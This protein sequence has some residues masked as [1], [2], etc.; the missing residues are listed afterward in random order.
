MIITRTMIIRTVTIFSLLVVMVIGFGRTQVSRAQSGAPQITSV[1]T[2]A[3]GSESATISYTANQDVTAQVVYDTSAHSQVSDYRST[4]GFNVNAATTNSFQL[5]GLQAG[6]TYHFRV[7]IKNAGGQTDTSADR[8]LTT[9]ASAGAGTGTSLIITNIRADCTA[10]QCRVAYSTNTNA[11]VELRWDLTSQ[12][13]FVDYQFSTRENANPPQSGLRSLLVPPAGSPGGLTAR[14]PYHYRLQATNPTVGS[15]VTNDLI[16]QTSSSNSDHTFS[17]GSCIVPSTGETV[18][19][20]SCASTRQYCD[21]GGQLV[22]SCTSICA[23]V[24]PAASTCNNSGQCIGDPAL[25]GSPYQCNQASCYNT[26]GQLI[27]PAPA[28][29]YGSWPSCNANTILKVRKDRGCNLWLTCGTSLQTEPSSVAPAENLCLSLAACNS[30]GKEGQCNKYLPQGQCSNDPLRFCSIDADCTAGGT[31]NT[32]P[33]DQPTQSLQNI[34]YQT[35]EDVAKIADLSGNVV[36]GLDWHQQGGS[37]VIQGYLPWQLMRQVGGDAQLKNGD[38]EY[39]TPPSIMPWEAAPLTGAGTTSLKVNFED[40][41]SGGTVSQNPNH[42]L[43]IQPSSNAINFPGAASGTFTASPSEYYY[44]EARVKAKSGTPKV[45]FQFGFNAYR[46][47]SVGTTPTYV[48]VDVT[49]AW[50]RVTLG[51]IRGMSGETR[52]AAVCADAA[53]CSEFWLDDVQVRPILQVDTTPTYITPSCRLYPK[54]DSPACDYVDQNNVIYKGWHGYCLEHDSQTGTCL[55]WWP[56]DIIQGQS[57][58]FGAETPAG[59]QDRAPLFLCA[60]AAGNSVPKNS[61][62]TADSLSPYRFQSIYNNVSAC[63]AGGV[64]CDNSDAR[65]Q[66]SNANSSC[67]PVDYTI[68]ALRNPPRLAGLSAGRADHELRESDIHTIRWVQ[69]HGG[70]PGSYVTAIVSND[71]NF[72]SSSPA[73]PVNVLA[74]GDTDKPYSIFR[75]TDSVTSADGTFNNTNCDSSGR[76]CDIAWVARGLG[77]NQPAGLDVCVDAAAVIFD[78]STGVVKQYVLDAW[79]TPWSTWSQ[80]SYREFEAAFKVQIGALETCNT[81]VQVVKPNGENQAFASRIDNPAYLVQ[82]TGITLNSDLKPFGGYTQPLNSTNPNTWSLLPIE[83]PD[84]VNFDP[85]GQ[86]RGGTPYACAGGCTDIVCTATGRSCLTAGTLDPSLVST[87]ETPNDP[88]INPGECTGVI[89]NGQSLKGAQQFSSGPQSTTLNPYF[90]QER[91]RRLFAQSY[92]IYQYGVNS[93]GQAGYHILQVNNVDVGWKPPTTI[94]PN[95][96]RPAFPNDYCAVPPSV[97]NASFLNSTAKLTTISSGSGSVGIKFNTNAN[98]DQVPLDS[99]TIDWGDEIKGIP[100]P[101]APRNDQT[102][103]HIFSHPYVLNRGDASHCGLDGSRQ[104][105]CTYNIKIQVKDNWGWCNDKASG[106]SS[107]PNASTNWYDTGLTVVITP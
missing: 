76:N 24:C 27:N 22:T 9:T 36:A 102:K 92:G 101:N 99:I 94:C 95:A 86:A 48:D 50:Q 74:E 93:L 49:N 89:N 52:V 34:T 105:V 80:E 45:R 70:S 104:Y 40:Q 78:K 16:F 64:P 42:V 107:C 15:F 65:N 5:T 62:Y 87:C 35:P 47:F 59:Y 18:P 75:T 19:I 33:G 79:A 39:N 73:N 31:C 61:N 3:V 2:T 103:P 30:L 81:I 28:G 46:S 71:N 13:N 84:Q 90:A 43:V 29:C 67:Q 8:T 38:F 91:M 26:A 25:N 57:N 72:K 54:D 85:S 56:V 66:C 51:P 37:N 88:N 106:N 17:T 100:F 63:I 55:S 20:G 10:T 32:S 58:I 96:T 68:R 7:Q 4:T 69:V 23:L 60:E 82:D 12:A 1:N 83:Q 53:N 14:T 6:T 21:N 11:T 77:C 44:A 98:A 41:T 97:S